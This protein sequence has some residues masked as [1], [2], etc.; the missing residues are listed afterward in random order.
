MPRCFAP[1]ETFLP[2]GIKRNRW[3]DPSQ[4][5]SPKTLERPK[6][7]DVPKPFLAEPQV[8]LSNNALSLSHTHKRTRMPARP[9]PPARARAAPARAHLQHREAY[10]SRRLGRYEMPRCATSVLQMPS[11]PVM[12]KG[13]AAEHKNHTSVGSLQAPLGHFPKIGGYPYFIPK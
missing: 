8:R 3:Q 1:K 12:E 6:S 5:L 10:G 13:G 4:A 9:K 7:P 11:C 2:S